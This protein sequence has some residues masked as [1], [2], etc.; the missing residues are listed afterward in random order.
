MVRC[1]HII[2]YVY[3]N[4]IVCSKSQNDNKSRQEILS[5]SDIVHTNDIPKQV[6]EIPLLLLL[7]TSAHLWMLAGPTPPSTSMSKSLYLARKYWTCKLNFYI[8]FQFLQYCLHFFQTQNIKPCQFYFLCLS[9]AG[10]SPW[11]LQ[12]P[13][14]NLNFTILT[15]DII[16]SINFCPP[17]PGSTVITSTM[18]TL[19]RKGTT[20][21]TG[22]PGFMAIPAYIKRGLKY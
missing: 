15:F 12:V 11:Q 21:S 16:S 10:H 2:I 18:S 20:V 1:N 19:S 22:V 9:F 4:N 6:I 13:T 3:Y 7:Y 5:I 8:K 14:V 17:N